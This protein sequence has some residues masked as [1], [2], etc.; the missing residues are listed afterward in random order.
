[1]PF[2]DVL[3][4]RSTVRIFVDVA[5]ILEKAVVSHFFDIRTDTASVARRDRTAD[6]DLVSRV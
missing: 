2:N 3:A 6:E 4:H 5:A 1:M